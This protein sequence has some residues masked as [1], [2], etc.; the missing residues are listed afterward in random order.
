MMLTKSL[1]ISVRSTQPSSG[2]FLYL[3]ILSLSLSF[4]VCVCVC[5][6]VSWC[7]GVMQGARNVQIDPRTQTPT[8]PTILR[9]VRPLIRSS[10][11]SHASVSVSM[12]LRC[13]KFSCISHVSYTGHR[14]TIAIQRLHT[15]WPLVYY[16]VC[17]VAAA[18]AAAADAANNSSVC[19][20]R[21]AVLTRCRANYSPPAPPI[22]WRQKQLGLTNDL[23]P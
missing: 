20:R 19:S 7:H 12:T 9:A 17:P 10:S 2:A 14:L 1:R 11:Y 5:V 4:C 21:R 6:C 13:G 8:L 15:R 22:D 23:R 16:A 18:A 3:F